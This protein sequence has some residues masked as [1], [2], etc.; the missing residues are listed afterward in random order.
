VTGNTF[1]SCLDVDTSDLDTAIQSSARTFKTY[2]KM[3]PR[4]RAE[5]L[6]SWYNLIQENRDDLAMLLTYE[7]GKPLKDAYAEIDYS[8]GFVWWFAS[9]AERIFGTINIPAEPNRRVFVH[10][11]PIGV[12]MA[13]VPWNLPIAMILPK[14]GA[15]FAASCTMV[16]KPSIETP[17][18]CFTL[19]YLTTKAGL[20]VG[21][22]N[23]LTTSHTNTASIS[24]AMCRHP[25]VGK[26]TFTGST[27]IGSLISKHCAEGVK[28][29]T[30]ELG[31]N[32]PFIIFN[33]ADLEHVVSELMTLKW[34]H[35][36]QACITANR[37][38]VQADVYDE[39]ACLPRKQTETLVQGHSAA[40]GTTF[41]AM[42]V[43]RGVEKAESL[44]KDAIDHGATLLCGSKGN[45]DHGFYFQPTILTGIKPIMWIADEEIFGP[46]LG[47]FKFETEDEV[48]EL[49]NNT[50]MGLARYTFTNDVNLLWRMLENLEAGMIG[51]GSQRSPSR[52][53]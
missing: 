16:V 15:A 23:V 41:S 35:V 20:Q 18:T 24:E 52:Y 33:D 50:V 1:S 8:T 6:L 11:Q 9:K 25:L 4:K 43:A 19:A 49:A 7:N 37:V 31:E 30:M 51:M 48:V 45:T 26:L 34:R 42:A 53:L 40:P 32:C 39:F 21:I 12:C 17:L 3:T 5:V 22:F 46:I 29:V 10:K 44:V 13:L 2:W 38:Y 36:G 28:R 14:A 47:L 27:K